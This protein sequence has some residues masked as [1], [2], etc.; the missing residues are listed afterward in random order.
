MINLKN[1][2]KELQSV[3]IDELMEHSKRFA[4]ETLLREVVDTVVSRKEVK[5]L[6]EP[7]RKD[8]YG[9]PDFKIYTASSIIGYVENK[10]ITEN[11]D[12]VLKSAQIKK[13][14]E[15]SPNILLTNY[16]EF[17]W[18]KGDNIQRETLCYASD[19]EN[20]K[21]KLDENKIQSVENILKNFFSEAPVGISNAKDLALALAVRSKNLK[22]F[23]NDD[24]ENQENAE[25]QTRLV[26]LYETFKSYVFN[27]LTISEFADAFAQMLVYGLFLAKLNADT[28]EVT[29]Y[30]AKK[31]IPQSFELI[32]ELV[33]FLDE[34]EAVNYKD[35][36]WIIDE[37]ISIMN[38]LA[39]DEIQKSLQFSKKVK[40]SE[41]IETDPYIYFYETFLAAYDKNLRK[42]K[43]VYYTPP[44]VVN[45]IVRSVNEVLKN[46]FKI[47]AGFAQPEKVTVLDFATGTGTF[48]IEILK[49]IFEAIPAHNKQFKEMLIKDHILKN[50]Y[51]FEYL[52][53]PYTIAHLKLSQFLKENNYELK[54]N[55]RFQLFLTNILEPIAEI[56]PNLYAKSLSKE[57]K[58]AQ[59]IKDK[60][61]LVITG[62]PPYSGHSKN[63]GK[64]ITNL[65]KGNDIWATE[66]VGKQAN[67]YKVEGKPLGERNPKWLQ[68]DYVKFSSF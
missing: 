56:K 40:D 29:L 11:L 33:G 16:L 51:G 46:T 28:K 15:L 68:D 63:T 8:N 20:K 57:G 6:H 39:L 32:R 37:V 5:V 43:G 52:I 18:I 14:R 55:E 30:N 36:R 35:T 1:Y 26:G 31:Y 54:D 61:I 17:L 59:K 12:N 67:Y 44:Q 21:I 19:L 45:F 48:I 60:P 23:L 22:D 24:L 65:L 34:L 10:K 50:I 7:K 62:N 4:L 64:W 47:E 42:T 49:Q 58:L 9:S 27:E 25:E 66:K 38:N 13:Y 2:I 3:S 53:A 41:N